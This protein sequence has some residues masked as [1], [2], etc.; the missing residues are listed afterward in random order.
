[1]KANSAP[2]IKTKIG[3]PI[4]NK[5]FDD[6]IL[7]LLDQCNS[8]PKETL[9]DSISVLPHKFKLVSGQYFKSK[10]H[11]NIQVAR[12]FLCDLNNACF[13]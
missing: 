4:Q 12:T 13:I 11:C 6:I 10:M 9:D 2:K 5:C 8:D 3:F 1:M 7:R